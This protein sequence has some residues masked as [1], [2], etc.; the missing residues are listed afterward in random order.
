MISLIRK[1]D[2]SAL[3][4]TE[5]Q[6]FPFEKLPK[7]IQLDVVEKMGPK[8]AIN[9]EAVSHA[10]RALIAN[11]KILWRQYGV[12]PPV[13]LFGTPDTLKQAWIES[14]IA[15]LSPEARSVLPRLQKHLDIPSD[16]VLHNFSATVEKMNLGL[17][18]MH[19]GIQDNHGLDVFIGLIY[20]QKYADSAGLEIPDLPAEQIRSAFSA[21]LSMFMGFAQRNIVKGDVSLLRGNLADAVVWSK[22][23]NIELPSLSLENVSPE[24][25]TAYLEILEKLK[26]KA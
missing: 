1:N 10:S 17:Q 14:R 19:Q 3:V 16:T 4:E 24:A 12:H 18:R 25:K 5:I 8:R 9:L 2:Q 21:T 6:K 23:L 20:A 26:S 15:M 13:V 22:R 7:E 11:N